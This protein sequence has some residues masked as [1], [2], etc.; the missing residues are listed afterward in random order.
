MRSRLDASGGIKEGLQ[1]C[2]SGTV[3]GRRTKKAKV[4][5][6]NNGRCVHLPRH[7][8]ETGKPTTNVSY[9]EETAMGSI[10]DFGLGI[11]LMDGSGVGRRGRTRRSGCRPGN[12]LHFENLDR[13]WGEKLS[14]VRRVV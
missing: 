11:D 7:V 6:M 2:H 14:E 10:K 4:S 9:A 13:E 8:I 12:G 1:V 5:R 3:K